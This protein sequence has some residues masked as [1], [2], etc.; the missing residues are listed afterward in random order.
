LTLAQTEVER[1]RRGA[2]RRRRAE[3]VTVEIIFG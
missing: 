2:M 3:R 1:V